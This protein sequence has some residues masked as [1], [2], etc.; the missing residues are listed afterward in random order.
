MSLEIGPEV[1]QEATCACGAAFVQRGFQ[2]GETVRFTHPTR[3]EACR[4]R[5]EAALARSMAERRE[6]VKAAERAAAAK[7]AGEALASLDAPP[8]YAGATLSGFALHGTPADRQVQGR[9]LQLARRYEG[10]WPD[11]EA[12]LL[13]R[14]GPG[15]GKGHI[16]WSLA[17]ALAAQGVRVAVVKLADLVREL[18]ASWRTPDA[19]S[20]AQVLARYRGLDLLV[21]DEVS[22]HAFYG[23]RIHQHLYDVLDHR[24]E[25][26]RPT[27]LTTNEDNAGLGDILR[28]ALVSRLIGHGQIVE[29]GSADYR[30][31]P[32]DEREAA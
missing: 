24:I 16:A 10:S 7:R 28:A 15:T 11:V 27:I 25:Y 30:Q 18:R 20:E 2:V 31:R 17:Q 22:R 5:A 8:L 9:I 23:E 29:F 1:V 6:D 13:F 12:V 4:D 26:Q 3:C 19:V 21:I 14:G 32:A